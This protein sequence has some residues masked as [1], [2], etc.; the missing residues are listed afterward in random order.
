M[1]TIMKK[2]P[3]TITAVKIREIVNTPF[4]SGISAHLS[5]DSSA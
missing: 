1:D 2:T 5:N 3:E 4:V